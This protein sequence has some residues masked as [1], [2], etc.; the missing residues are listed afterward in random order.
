VL[1][2]LEG[3]GVVDVH[4]TWSGKTEPPPWP[5]HRAYASLEDWQRQVMVP[6]ADC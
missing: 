6:D 1:F 4:L 3:G 2:R 5:S